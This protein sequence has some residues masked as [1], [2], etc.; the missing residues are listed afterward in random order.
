[1]YMTITHVNLSLSSQ[2]KFTEVKFGLK[3]EVSLH[4][5]RK[6][7]VLRRGGQVYSPVL[8]LLPPCD[9]HLLSPFQIFTFS[10]P[11]PHRN[12]STCA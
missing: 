11:S 10:S 3:S 1:M 2:D 6:S 8:Q 5:V 7:I 12:P 9:T 4:T